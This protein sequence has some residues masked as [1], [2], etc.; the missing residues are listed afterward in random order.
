M[1]D[2]EKLK[3]EVSSNIE[4]FSTE[5]LLVSYWNLIRSYITLHYSDKIVCFYSPDLYDSHDFI[6]YSSINVFNTEEDMMKYYN[7]VNNP[8]ESIVIRSVNGKILD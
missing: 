7:K 4:E 3:G 2:T 1:T 6:H 8:G 5:T